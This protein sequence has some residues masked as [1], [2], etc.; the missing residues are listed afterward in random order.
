MRLLEQFAIPM[1]RRPPADPVLC[2]EEE[3]AELAR[4]LCRRNKNSP[5]LVGPPGVGKTALVEELARRIAR[6]Q[7]PPQLAGKRIWSLNMA[8]LVAG[9]KYRG[10][11][12]ERV[13][14]LLAETAQAGNVILFLDELHTLMGAG[15]AE[16]SI[17]AANLLKPALGRGGVQIIGATTR[18]EYS[19]RVEADPALARRFRVVELAPATVAQSLEIL[20]ALAPG[21]E[22]HHGV[23]ILSQAVEAAVRL[24]ER[25]LPGRFLPDKAV[26]LLDEAAA[27]VSLRGTGLVDRQAVALTLQRATGIPLRRLRG[28]DRAALR[29]LERRLGEAV[30]GQP[31][32][33]RSA[34]AAVRRGRLGLGEPNRP[35]A[36]LLFAGPTGVGKTALCKAL[37]REVYGC[38]AAMLRLDMSEYAQEHTAA[39]L[40][41]APPG[42]VGHGKGGEL[43]ERV[44]ARPHSLILLDE[45]E[46]AH[47]SVTA[48]LLQILE[49]GRLTDGLGR[50]A[51]FRNVLLVMTTN[52]GCLGAKARPGFAAAGLT[53]GADAKSGG[54]APGETE[55][56]DRLRDAFSPELLGRMDAVV[57]FR[58]LTEKTLEQIA[59]LRLRE[60]LA[61]VEAAGLRV[62]PEPGFPARL[63]KQS[64]RDPAG[65]R[66]I[67][68][69]LQTEVL[70]PAAEL[71]LQ[72]VTHAELTPDGLRPTAK[73]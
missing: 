59:A 35:A 28:G 11:F 12:E 22:R 62:E 65:A 20:T 52:A 4:I 53:A 54:A 61:R 38:E 50:T 9:T 29:E 6:G 64:A 66:A 41:G 24:S 63:A 33:V 31:E 25:Y 26:D 27:A 18:E 58:P 15:G 10:E 70:D 57:Q 71:I 68:H 7:V 69:L 23:C 3:L 37:A 13:R 19:R 30:L 1:D 45:L 5:A 49:D 48:L 51:D 21:L 55:A 17:D 42:Y 67:R 14:D 73:V 72:G 46:K 34:A 47:P 43:T 44:R 56:R 39:R 8:S 40:L 60:A 2:R 16:G 36:A 32:A